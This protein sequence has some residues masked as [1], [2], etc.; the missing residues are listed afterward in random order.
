MPNEE[1]FVDNMYVTLDKMLPRV[2]DSLQKTDLNKIFDTLASIKEPTIVTGVGG[3]SIV[4]TFLAKVLNEKNHIIATFK[5]P[6]D[7]KL[8]DLNGYKNVIAVSYSG[9]NIGVD[10]S[11][12][13]NLNKYLLSGTTRPGI[14]SL[15][16]TVNDEEYSF[17]SMAGTFI[18]LSIILM[19]Y[20][21][22]INLVKDILSIRKEF[23][24]V[25]KNVYE[26]MTSE[27]SVTACAMLD[28]TLVEG[29]L[30]APVIHEKYDYCHGRTMFNYHYQNPLIYFDDNSALDTL[31]KENLLQT[32]NHVIMID[33]KYDD[34]IIND[35]YQ[36]Y[37]GLLL[38]VS[39]AKKINRDM[40]IKSVPDIS[41]LI[42][43]YKGKM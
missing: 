25:D 43:T 18:P 30:V 19:Y 37:M 11:F 13:N 15:Q 22:D 4:G 1:L 5:F 40:S 28:S 29:A 21:N 27:K 31:F 35:Y 32:Y 26:I 24:V 10:A 6:R 3:S 17:V 41:E 9:K 34:S 7:L 2:L 16:Y 39:I 38:C 14:N 8:M 20:K 12:D 42:Y 23:D 33:S 36:A